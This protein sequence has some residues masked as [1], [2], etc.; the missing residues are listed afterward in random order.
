V[1]LEGVFFC[2][3]PWGIFWKRFFGKKVE[4][5]LTGE[6]ILI[7]S[8]GFQELEVIFE[9]IFDVSEIVKNLI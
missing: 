8:V 6:S 3:K 4:K 7:Q 5:C 2:R 9:A 1:F